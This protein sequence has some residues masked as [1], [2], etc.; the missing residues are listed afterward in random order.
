[1]KIATNNQYKD[2]FFN[3]LDFPF[4]PGKKILDIGCG[5]GMDGHIF[6]NQ[7]KLNTYGI[8]IYRHS[9]IKQLKKFHF[10]LGSIL[11]IPFPNKSFDYVFLHDVLHHIDEND[12]DRKKH[13]EALR[14]IKRICRRNGYIIIVEA[15]RY[16]PIFYPHMVVLKGHN[17]FTRQYFQKLIR[18]VF[19]LSEFEHFEAH[20]YPFGLA[21][22]FRIY[23]LFMEKIPVFKNFLAY[24]VAI[25]RK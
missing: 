11:D 20:V 17:H 1:M 5:D 6:I 2:D 15:N 9:G 8:D 24:N 12:Q 13:L 10:K 7:Y 25:I 19:S 16:N 22:I 3:K 18:T 14:E 23:E 21:P 4:I